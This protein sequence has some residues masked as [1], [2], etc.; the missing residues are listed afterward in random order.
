MIL[1]PALVPQA[2]ELTS[3]NILEGNLEFLHFMAPWRGE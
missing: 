1:L 2:S 3:E